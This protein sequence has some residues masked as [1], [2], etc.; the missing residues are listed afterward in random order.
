M[1]KITLSA[2]WKIFVVLAAGALAIGFIW[3]ESSRLSPSPAPSP[4]R[5]EA[6]LQRIRQLSNADY[7][8]QQAHLLDQ[9]QKLKGVPPQAPVRSGLDMLMTHRRDTS[10]YQPAF[11]AP[12]AMI[13]SGQDTNSAQIQ[14]LAQ[15]GSAALNSVLPLLNNPELTSGMPPEQAKQF[16]QLKNLVIQMQSQISSGQPLTSRQN[17]QMMRLLKQIMP[18]MKPSGSAAEEVCTEN[19]SAAAAGCQ[20]NT[21]RN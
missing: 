6:Q 4:L 17:E 1:P 7:S 5:G 9:L 16:N 21:P 3:L 18:S 11:S 12:G 19:S 20:Q 2:G 15:K 14:A 8:A 10:Q 13:Q